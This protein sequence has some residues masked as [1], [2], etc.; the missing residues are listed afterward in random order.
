MAKVLVISDV[1]GNKEQLKTLI[2]ENEF[3][4]IIFCGDMIRD[5]E[6]INHPNIVKVKGNW[7]EWV[8]DRDNLFDEEVVVEG[9]KIFVTHGHRY[10]VK[11][12]LGGL[13]RRVEGKGFNLVCYGHTHIQD[14][15]V[16]N[17]IAYL[18]PGAFS[19][20]KGG[21]QT[22]AVVEIEDGKF[23]VNM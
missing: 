14:F 18:N 5:L 2:S 21:K 22:F 6:E 19:Y 23:I 12:G 8:I 11:R 3:T 20:F 9:V 4:H 10:D 17:D 16:V 1:H 7:D 13:I 15:E